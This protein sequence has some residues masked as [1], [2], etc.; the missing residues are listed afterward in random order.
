MKDLLRILA[1]LFAL[2]LCG[3]ALLTG[4]C[5]IL[6]TPALFQ[7][8]EFAGPDLLPIWA[9]GLGI[10][11]VCITIAVLIF[12]RLSRPALPSAA[13]FAGEETKD[14]TKSP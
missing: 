4:G 6:F 3:V 14:E 9:T 7:S 13:T 2:I 1:F 8:G 5:S 12:R 11:A 10:A